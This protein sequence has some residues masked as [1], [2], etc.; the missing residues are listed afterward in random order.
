MIRASWTVQIGV[1]V[2]RCSARFILPS[3]TARVF[4]LPA[5]AADPEY[6]TGA[7]LLS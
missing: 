4:S 7:V 6:I 3:A 1:A 5:M 2:M